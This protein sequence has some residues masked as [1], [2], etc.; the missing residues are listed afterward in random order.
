MSNLL[1]GVNQMMAHTLADSLYFLNLF[2]IVSVF[3]I[4]VETL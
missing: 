1:D 4:K 2:L 3:T